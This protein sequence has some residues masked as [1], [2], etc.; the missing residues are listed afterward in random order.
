MPRLKITL[1]RTISAWQ[2]LVEDEDDKDD[3][4]HGAAGDYTQACADALLAFDDMKARREK[5]V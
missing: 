2:W 4:V 3:F 5:P 1:A